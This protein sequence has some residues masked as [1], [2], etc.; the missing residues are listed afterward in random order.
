[1]AQNNIRQLP[2][3]H[4]RS[5]V[6]RLLRSVA[7]PRGVERGL[8]T[9]VNSLELAKSQLRDHLSDRNEQIRNLQAHATYQ[10]PISALKIEK[11]RTDHAMEVK[12]LEDE[13]AQA[14][15][16]HAGETKRLKNELEQARAGYSDDDGL[17]E[18]YHAGAAILTKQAAE[19]K[20]LR[21]ENRISK[22]DLDRQQRNF[23]VMMEEKDHEKA[24]LVEAVQ[25]LEGRL[26]SLTTDS[27]EVEVDLKRQVADVKD[28][29]KAALTRS[30]KLEGDVLAHGKMTAEICR[31]E[32][33]EGRNA[34]LLERLRKVEQCCEGYRDTATE[35]Q[36]IIEK[37]CKENAKLVNG[38]GR[39]HV[40][41]E[42]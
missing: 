35:Q 15:T 10:S 36:K 21:A 23:I 34:D 41:H 18:L 6:R 5:T 28:Q 4:G 33:A 17:V 24:D 16:D 20:R 31:R 40:H 11:M 26:A 2:A 8:L 38:L 22:H 42:S 7:I 1:M 27:M 19:L 37:L 13:L 25:R 30:R 29:L 3:E 14:H 9:L 12:R 32:A 39:Q